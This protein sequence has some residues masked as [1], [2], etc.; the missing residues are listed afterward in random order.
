M[1]PIYDRLETNIPRGLMGFTDLNWPAECQLFPEHG[2]VLSY[3]EQYA[4][5]VLHLIKFETQVVD[6]RLDSSSKWHV[7]TR[8]LRGS[9]ESV[10]EHHDFDAVV[11]AS[12]YPLSRGCN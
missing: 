5:D 1:S 8:R 6:V 10:V 7:Q 4:Q 3:L 9:P 12:S 2:T 11:V